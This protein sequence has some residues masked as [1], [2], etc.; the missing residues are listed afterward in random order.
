MGQ[1]SEFAKSMVLHLFVSLPNSAVVSLIGLLMERPVERHAY[2]GFKNPIVVV[3]KATWLVPYARCVR[4]DLLEADATNVHHDLPAMTALI[5]V[6]IGAVHNVMFAL[7]IS[8][9]RIVN[10]VRSITPVR[11]ATVVR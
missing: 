3:A 8:S 6:A 1:T 11:H 9:S 10:L 2:L 4:W 7:Q 5:A